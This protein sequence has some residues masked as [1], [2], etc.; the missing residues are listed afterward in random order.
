[1]FTE[2][3]IGRTHKTMSQFRP[4]SEFSVMS[5][6]E[7]LGRSEAFLNQ[8]RTRRTVREFSARPVAREVVDNCL[9]VAMAAPSGANQQPWTFVIIEGAELRN[10]LRKAAEQEEHEF[11]S[12]RAPQE[13]LNALAPFG[14]D[15]SKPFLEIA[16]VLIAIFAQAWK[17]LPDGG[18]GKHYY[19]NESVGIATG[20]LI[21]ALHNAGLATLTHTPSPMNFL[22][23][24]L[25]RP[26]NER[27]FLLLV[28]GYPSDTCCV[29]VIEKKAFSEVV[30][31]SI[32]K[33]ID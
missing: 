21:A 4:Y 3:S 15:A 12:Q 27:P 28:A 16:P 2:D 23:Q 20:F 30:V 29:P 13:W 24:L 19:V 31:R 17:R 26:E 11:Y 32:E 22:N 14:T 6:E 8:M 33:P 9:K 25:G 7:S 1:M 10:R 18:R 5:D